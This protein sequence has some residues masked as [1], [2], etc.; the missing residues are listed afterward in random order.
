MGLFLFKKNKRPLYVK[1]YKTVTQPHNGESRKK[2]LK[3]QGFGTW[4]SIV[5]TGFVALRFSVLLRSVLR[6]DG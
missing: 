1:R 3:G 2:T 5:S 6:L 4:L